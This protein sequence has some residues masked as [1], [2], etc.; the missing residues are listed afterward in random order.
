MYNNII[1][2]DLWQTNHPPPAV[3]TAVLRVA[4]YKQ[5]YQQQENLGVSNA[6]TL[7]DS[8]TDI[9]FHENIYRHRKTGM[10]LDKIF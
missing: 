4:N 7:T 8:L 6:Y 10:T 1:H 9:A 2:Q 3:T 5:H